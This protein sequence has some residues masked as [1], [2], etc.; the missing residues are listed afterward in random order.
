MNNFKNTSAVA[1]IAFVIVITI[2]G[3]WTTTYQSKNIALSPTQ[4]SVTNQTSDVQSICSDMTCNS[5]SDFNS[6]Q[7]STSEIIKKSIQNS[8]KNASK[9]FEHTKDDVNRHLK[10]K[11]YDN[12]VA[13]SNR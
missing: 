1:I 8:M 7:P 13:Y 3:L 12:Y 4:Y 6:E 11:N 9:W 10:H 5:P 2:L